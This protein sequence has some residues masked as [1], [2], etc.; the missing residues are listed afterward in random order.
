MRGGLTYWWLGMLG[1]NTPV[2]NPRPSVVKQACLLRNGIPRATW[3]ETG[4]FKGETTRFLA[5][6]ATKVYSLEPEPQL[7]AA[8]VTSLADLKNVELLSETSERAVPKLVANAKSA[9]RGLA[10][11]VRELLG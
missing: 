4:T 3:I 1:N 8:A 6:H 11:A 10:T 9:G 5:R 7:Y 2:A